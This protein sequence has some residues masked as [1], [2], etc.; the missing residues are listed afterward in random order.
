MSRRQG[1]GSSI[2]LGKP[3]ATPPGVFIGRPGPTILG[4]SHQAKTSAGLI[5]DFSGNF[6]VDLSTMNVI[7]S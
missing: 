6:I 7:L 1:N 3:I 2:Y 5:A 4:S